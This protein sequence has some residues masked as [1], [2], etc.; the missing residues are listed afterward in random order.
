MS[1]R[2]KRH[3][4][5]PRTFSPKFLVDVDGRSGFVKEIRRR[6]DALVEDAGAD[7]Y[8][9]KLI[10]TEAIFISIQLET[11]RSNAIE[12]GDLDAGVYTQMVNALSGLLAKL[13]LER[14]VSRT[15]DLKAYVAGAKR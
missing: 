7:S 12:G 1:K 2:K 14:K 15:V 5:L 6:L 8:Q 9:K 13:G 3:I 4:S 11:M 10:A